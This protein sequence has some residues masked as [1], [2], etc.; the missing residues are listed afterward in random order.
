[1]QP[2]DCRQGELL[3]FHTRKTPIYPTNHNCHLFSLSKDKLFTTSAA[4]FVF[5]I[6][7]NWTAAVL[8]YFASTNENALE[9][10]R[11]REEV[12][13]VK[14][15]IAIYDLPKLDFGKYVSS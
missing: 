5:K 9:C 7:L 2:K 15:E 3:L 1:M 4:F 12:R 13:P 8:M 11:V 14:S 10:H 6:P